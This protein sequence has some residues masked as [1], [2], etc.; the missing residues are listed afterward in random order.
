[1]HRLGQA[2]I[3]V[4]MADRPPKRSLPWWR[5]VAAP[6][7]LVLGLLA[8]TIGAYLVDKMAEKEALREFEFTAKEAQQIVL[9]RVRACEQ[10]L[11][12]GAAVMS[13]SEHVSREEWRVFV[14]TQQAGY[15]LPG[16]VGIGFASRV[17]AG[18]LQEHERMVRGEG[19]PAYTVWPS[20]ERDAYAAV[21]YLEP[22]SQQNLRTL[23]YDMLSEPVRRAAMERA[24]DQHT[25]AL[26]GKVTLEQDPED[27]LHPGT[28]LYFPVY[29]AAAPLGSIEERR[30]ALAGW[31]YIPL[32]VS[33]LINGALRGWEEVFVYRGIRFQI[34]DGVELSDEHLLFSNRL[35]GSSAS[36]S[37]VDLVR[38]SPVQVAGHRWTLRLT[39]VGGL[40]STKDSTKTWLALFAGVVISVLTFTLALSLQRTTE[41]AEDRAKALTQELHI[42]NERLALATRAGGVGVWEYDL[43]GR[44]LNWDDQMLKIYGLARHQFDGGFQTWI[45]KVH[46][47]DKSSVM[48]DLQKALKG[49]SPF[50]REFRVIWPDRSVH[51]IRASGAVERNEAG[52]AVRM[53]G[54]NWDITESKL[55]EAAYQ[56]IQSQLGLAMNLAHLAHWEMDVGSGKFIFNDGFYALYATSAAQ[57]GGYRMPVETYAREFIP[58]EEQYVVATN[59][60]LLVAGE[61]DEIRLEHRITRRDG[62]VRHLAVNAVALRDSSGRVV[63]IRGANQDITELREKEWQLADQV[64]RWKEALLTTM[65]GYLETDQHG[66]I[67]EANPAYTAIS[68]YSVTELTFKKIGDLESVPQPIDAS[69]RSWESRGRRGSHRFRTRH[70]RK[71]GGIVLLEVSATYSPRFGGRFYYF[72]RDITAQE[73]AERR[74]ELQTTALEAAANAILITNAE[75]EIEWVNEA[76]VRSSGY[77]R[78]EAVGANPRIV[79]SGQHARQFFEEMWA[80][81]RSGKVWQ[82]E[83]VNRRKDG[84]LLVEETL[85]TPVRNLDGNIAHF[86]AIKQ[87]I[88]QRK[89]MERQLLRSQRMEAVGLLAGGM[90]HDLNNILT[91]ILLSVDLLKPSV[92]A[93]LHR[94]VIDRIGLAARRGAGVIRQVLTFARGIEGARAPLRPIDLIREII[95]MIEET[96]PRDIRIRQEASNLCPRVAGDLTQLHQVLLNLVVNARDAM[97]QGGVLTLGL[98]F[99]DSSEK[100]ILQTGELKPGG[101]VIIKVQDTGEGIAPQIASQIFEPFFTNKPQGKGTGLGLSTALGIVRSHGGLIDFHSKVGEGSEFRI[102]LPALAVEVAEPTEPPVVETLE[103][104]GRTVLLVDDE[105]LIRSAARLMLENLGFNVI[106]VENGQEGLAAFEA[107]ASEVYCVVTDVMMPVMSGD[108]LAAEIWRRNPNVPIL[109]MSGLMDRDQLDAS[110]VKL[111]GRQSVILKKP[112]Q[113]PEFIRVLAKVLESSKSI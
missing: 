57:E 28:V 15:H 89:K 110:F 40:S 84:T 61:V 26:S 29:K 36:S 52:V 43:L 113:I 45:E 88:T 101:Y 8:T 32:R 60:N 24:C 12:S 38:L 73:E 111:G 100:L 44:V 81:I 98:D 1:M 9:A 107:N 75:G 6:G 106:E 48:D 92:A 64:L 4:R 99:V 74:L 23:G 2:S 47:D 30:R 39:Q 82:G 13:A 85:I 20:G 62:V 65:D 80:T 95:T 72:C 7:L 14:E 69:T 59:A 79:N 19:F 86:V 108:K 87:D 90:A 5:R 91:P 58:A 55:A 66:A 105:D 93:P 56:R 49:T 35:V 17:L 27:D 78:E 67:L 96:F 103:G 51:F 18:E 34:F 25:S 83:I 50:N 31:V 42:S 33:D 54:T 68:G 77:S 104:K 70:R 37:N 112:F 109:F 21:V 94:E 102:Y 76:F 3:S 97:P 16:I 63:G 11:R 46:P 53:V 41:R 10:V 22:S 71:D